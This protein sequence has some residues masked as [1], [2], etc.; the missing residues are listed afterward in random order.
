M[1]NFSKE[2]VP[3]I[4]RYKIRQPIIAKGEYVT[5][6][7][8]LYVSLFLYQYG[9]SSPKRIWAYYLKDKEAYDSQIFTSFNHL[10][11]EILPHMLVAGKVV[12]GRAVDIPK[13]KRSGNIYNK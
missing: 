1:L 13:Y 4:A 3:R 7:P 6:G 10:K 9:V 11:R 12:K 8:H 2:V 5:K